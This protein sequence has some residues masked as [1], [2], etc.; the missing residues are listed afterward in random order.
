M[1]DEKKAEEQPKFDLSTK[2]TLDQIK[3]VDNG[4]VYSSGDKASAP[5]KAK[6]VLMRADFNVPLD[7]DCNITDK[8]RITSTIPTINKLLE[9]NPDRLVITSHLGRPKGQKKDKL[10]LAPVAAELESLLKK[11]VILVKDWFRDDL[12]SEVLA[13]QEKGAIILLE[14]VRFYIEEEGKGEDKDKN[15]LKAKEEEVKRFR[16]ILTGIADLFVCDAFGTC[17]RGHSSMVGCEA[18]IK[19]AGTVCMLACI[20]NLHACM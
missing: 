8:T 11:K 18:N 12:E 1:A 4:F 7:D 9:M 10:S 13:K 20:R 17:H 3:A 15:K 16:A 14:N 5:T 19:A 6:R 2:V